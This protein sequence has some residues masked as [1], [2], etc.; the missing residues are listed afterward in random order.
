MQDLVDDF[1]QRFIRVN[2]ENGVR[3]DIYKFDEFIT[4]PEDVDYKKLYSDE[5]NKEIENILQGFEKQVNK[6]GDRK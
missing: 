4:C 6:N 1:G 3:S 5:I 2:F